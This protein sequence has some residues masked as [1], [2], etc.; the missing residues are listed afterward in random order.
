MQDIA[1]I[2][3]FNFSDAEIRTI[4]TPKGETYF[5]A[6]DVCKVLELSNVGQALARLDEDEKSYIISNDV[7]TGTPKLSIITESGLYSLVLGSKK[8]EAKAFKKWVTSEVLPAI[9]KTGKYEVVRKSTLEMLAE[10]FAQMAQ[11]EKAQL[12]QSEE[13]KALQESQDAT[14]GKLHE[15][16][17]KV[18]NLNNDFYSLAGYYGLKHEKWNL[19]QPQAQQTGKKLKKISSELGYDTLSVNDARYGAVRTYH[20]HVLQTVLGF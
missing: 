19:S 8:A 3:K 11:L 18:T 17:A 9:R 13:L 20:V 2:Q 14:A 12:E 16:E 5:V 10:G 7:S 1:E 4:T 15:V 6:S